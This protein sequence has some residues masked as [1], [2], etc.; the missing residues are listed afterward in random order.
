MSNMKLPDSGADFT[1]PEELK[2]QAFIRNPYP[3]KE[4]LTKTEALDAA[5]LLIGMVLLHERAEESKK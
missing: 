4:T 2:Y 5:N 3:G 1:K